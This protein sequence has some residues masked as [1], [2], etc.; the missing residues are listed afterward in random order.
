[1]LTNKSI[2]RQDQTTRQRYGVYGVLA[3]EP[4]ITGTEGAR[5]TPQLHLP[6]EKIRMHR[7]Q[8]SAVGVSPHRCASMD[9]R[10]NST[11]PGRLID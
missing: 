10:T 7:P 11:V 1:M 5:D 3:I 9:D 4:Q 8:Y 2:F 6:P